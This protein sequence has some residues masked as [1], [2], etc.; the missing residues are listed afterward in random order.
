MYTVQI[1]SIRKCLLYRG[2]QYVYQRFHNSPF[3]LSV[4]DRVNKEGREEGEDQDGDGRH[5]LTLHQPQLE[6]GWE[7]NPVRTNEGQS[8]GYSCKD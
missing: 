5:C 4:Y 3:D 1:H 6:D 2:D 7:G 8:S